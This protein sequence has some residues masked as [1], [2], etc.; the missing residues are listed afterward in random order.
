ML[1]GKCAGNTPNTLI[2]DAGTVLTPNTLI[3]DAGTVLVSVPL[4]NTDG[5]DSGAFR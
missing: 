3:L 5:Q 2:L 4:D 1:L